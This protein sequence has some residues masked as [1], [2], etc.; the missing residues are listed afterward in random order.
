MKNK[1][2][3]SESELKEII[4]EQ[5]KNVLNENKYIRKKPNG[6]W[7]IISAKTGKFWDANYDTKEDAEDGFKAYMAQNH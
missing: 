7:G 5:V 6:K 4:Q 1:I 2:I 3:V